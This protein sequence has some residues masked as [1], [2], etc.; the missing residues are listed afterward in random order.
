MINYRRD[1][2]RYKVDQYGSLYVDY[3]KL[4]INE[5][6]TIYIGGQMEH[7]LHT[8]EQTGYTFDDC[9]NFFTG[10]WFYDYSVFKKQKENVNAINFGNNLLKAIEKSGLREVD[11]ITDSYGGLVGAYAT[12]SPLIHKV[13]AVHPPVLGSP[14]ASK[15][16]INK[17]LKTLNFQEYL[18]A[19]IVKVILNE[20]Y[21]F[22]QENRLG[23]D[24][25]TIAYYMD[26]AKM[27]IVGSNINPDTEKNVVAKTLY[28]II[29]T[30]SG[31]ITD[32]FV[33]FDEREFKKLGLNY[34]KENKNLNHFTAGSKE[35]INMAYKR[36]LKQ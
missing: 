9:H 29:N 33:S 24:S 35:N 17:V 10:S 34:V 5:R 21:G 8:L 2:E 27:I 26:K 28:S 12:K 36:C 32:G 15:K 25:P 16:A 31:E 20:N 6:P 22:Q 11:L 3:S 23:I 13:V 30:I 14:L 7:R 19:N 4:K 18:I 1:K